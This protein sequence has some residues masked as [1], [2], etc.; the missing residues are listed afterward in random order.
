[1]QSSP[2]QTPVPI[3][4]LSHNGQHVP[5]SRVPLGTLT[6]TW[7]DAEGHEQEQVLAVLR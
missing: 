1:M 3:N 7:T 4:G 2:Q 5:G 6:G